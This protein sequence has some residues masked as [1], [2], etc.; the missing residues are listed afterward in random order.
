MKKAYIGIEYG[1]PASF[2]DAG[3]FFA[4]PKNTLLS[5]I[6]GIRGTVF[7]CGKKERGCREDRDQFVGWI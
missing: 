2:E 6:F 4:R 1:I 5:Q 7:R 3:I